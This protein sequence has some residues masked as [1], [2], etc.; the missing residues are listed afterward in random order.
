MR[1]VLLVCWAAVLPWCGG[2]CGAKPSGGEPAAPAA[3]APARGAF[4]PLD[5]AQPKLAT[6]KLWL[7]DQELVTEVARRPH[8]I[9]TGMMYR[10]NLAE[11]EA[12]LFL[13]PTPQRASF[14]MRNTTVPL[15]AAYLDPEGTILEIHDL[16]PLEEKPVEAQASNVQ[17][18]LETTQGW[19]RRHNLGPGVVVR[20]QYGALRALDRNLQQPRRVP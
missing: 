14:Y 17:F 10:T 7:G 8:E 18:V 19:F 11:N 5:H 16:Q 3:T 1:S 9:M 13:L 20:T 4:A 2:G 12:M 15:S 6:I